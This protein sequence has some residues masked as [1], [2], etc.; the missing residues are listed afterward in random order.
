MTAKQKGMA[1][2]IV[3]M[4]LAI[5]AALAA[6]MT[7]RFQTDMQR[8]ELQTVRL[9][10]Q[11][12]L[13]AAEES[14][15]AILKQDLADNPHMTSDEQYWAQP[16]TLN[17]DTG[18]TVNA[19]LRDDQTC[20]NLNALADVPQ[21]PQTPTPYNVKVFEELLKSE[22][23]NNAQAAAL[24]DAI[25]D[26]IDE[27]NHSRRFGAEDEYY[28]NAKTA[29]RTAG[30]PLFSISELKQIKGMTPELYRQLAPVLCVLP[31]KE[32]QINP[33]NLT[34]V[35]A[36][37]L[38]AL[39][40]DQFSVENAKE[41]I[42]ERPKGGWRAPA[43]LF[44]QMEKQFPTAGKEYAEVKTLLVMH[45]KFFSLNSTAIAGDY[46]QS[47]QSRFYYD[48]ETSKLSLF[49][50]RFFIMDESGRMP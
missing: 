37:L 16:Q 44:Q 29:H 26:F 50:R 17:F 19:Q 1:L 30:Q 20:Y 3:L 49:S 2:L 13:R 4:I 9:E 31:G 21:E 7:L 12:A 41:L 33:N 25:A 15:A 34:E 42:S 32:I 22:G 46:S 11:W 48:R 10:Q 35:Q 6:E 38:A 39:F 27:D 24:V 5:M 14:A 18:V 36:P 45:S 8:S 40:I 28:R 43:H 23:V 47:M